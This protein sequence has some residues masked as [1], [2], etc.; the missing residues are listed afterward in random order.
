[1][2]LL[3]FFFAGLSNSA[4]AQETLKSLEPD[5][6]VSESKSLRFHSYGPVSESE[7]KQMI[8]ERLKQLD[9]FL[10]PRVDPYTGRTELPELCQKNHLPEVIQKNTDHEISYL[11]SLY[12]SGSEVLGLCINKGDLLKTQY[13]LLY[14]RSLK[15]LLFIS[16]FYPVS[17]P[18]MQGPIA[19]C[20]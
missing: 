4:W 12:S 3:L 16:H 19:Q 2:I 14:C 6:V 9:G 1:M 20:R 17:D 7:A 10:A 13:L 18:W 5:F 15:K 8:Q 11:Y